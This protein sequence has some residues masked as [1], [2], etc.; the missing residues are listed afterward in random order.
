MKTS[1]T[2]CSW[3]YSTFRRERARCH[4]TSSCSLLESQ[5]SLQE[6]VSVRCSSWCPYRLT[7]LPNCLL[8]RRLSLL[9]IKKNILKTSAHS[10][11]NVWLSWTNF[12]ILPKFSRLRPKHFNISRKSVLNLTCF[13]T[14][15]WCQW[16][17]SAW[18]TNN[19]LQ[20]KKIK[21]CQRPSSEWF[22]TVSSFQSKL[23]MFSG[24][25]KASVYKS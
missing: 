23:W 24:A 15:S 22:P 13:T 21:T 10:L 6:R 9:I 18:L 12:M 19:H 11:T 7:S 2:R 20:T 3:E 1:S 17:C 16:N 4:L 14:R 25:R 8:H 5:Y